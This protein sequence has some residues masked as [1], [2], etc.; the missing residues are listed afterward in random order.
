MFTV[1]KSFIEKVETKI[2]KKIATA[3]SKNISLSMVCVHQVNVTGCA[4]NISFSSFQTTHLC[5]HSHTHTHTRTYTYSIYSAFICNRCAANVAVTICSPF[6]LKTVRV[7]DFWNYVSI[8][9]PLNW[10]QFALIQMAHL[11]WTI[12]HHLYY[13]KI[14]RKAN[15]TNKSHLFYLIPVCFKRNTNECAKNQTIQYK[16]K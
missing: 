2:R 14:Q 1:S 9:F 6:H 10:L 4:L 8:M 12:A 15:T 3:N 16:I 7:I 13:P 11:K 5:A